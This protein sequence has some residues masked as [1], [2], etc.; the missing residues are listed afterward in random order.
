VSDPDHP[1]DLRAGTDDFYADATYY[2]YEFRA[3]R[4]DVRWY[5]THYVDSGGP[6]LEL[7]VGSGRTAMGAARAGIDVVGIDL[8]PSMLAQAAKR[9]ARLAKAKR[10]HLH[11]IRADMRAFALDRL[12]SLIACPFNCFQHLYERADVERCL[13]RVRAHLEPDGLFLLDVLVPDLDYLTRPPFKRFPGVQFKHPTYGVP[14]TYSE[15]SAYD[16]IRQL[17]QMWFHYD[18]AGEE[19]GPDHVCA[20]LSH[21]CFFPAEL[22]ALLHYNGFEVLAAYGDFEQ[23]SLRADSES[24]VLVCSLRSV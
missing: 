14:Y 9:R 24:Q 21:R 12:F 3:R 1:F 4:G 8:S 22:E 5:T 7:G 16:P 23:G 6:V 20:Q 11:L 18:R 19:G 2:D 17:N 10:R 15:Q 13:E